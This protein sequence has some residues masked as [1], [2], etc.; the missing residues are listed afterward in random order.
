M[1][2]NDG[3]KWSIHR[4]S[5][6]KKFFQ[7][8]RER[9]Q[10]TRQTQTAKVYPVKPVYVVDQA[11]MDAAYATILHWNVNYPEELLYYYDTLD[12]SEYE[13]VVS[14]R[15][16][17]P[18][19]VQAI[20]W[21]VSPI[22]LSQSLSLKVVDFTDKMYLAQK[23]K[24]HQEFTNIV[25]TEIAKFDIPVRP[26]NEL[27]TSLASL[28]SK[29]TEEEGE[30]EKLMKAPTKK[31]VAPSMRMQVALSDPAVQRMQ[32]QIEKTKN[33]ISAYEKYIADADNGWKQLKHLELRHQVIQE[34]LKV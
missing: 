20:L 34:M 16:D 2:L 29:L 27:D 7:D 22:K 32:A 15:N 4:M 8:Q 13:Y 1:E 31:Y 5:A 17:F 18:A 10:R 3:F 23:L 33:E 26:S 11:K 28:R 12:Q 6:I 25:N 19:D 21:G 14:K 24:E 30:L 9:N